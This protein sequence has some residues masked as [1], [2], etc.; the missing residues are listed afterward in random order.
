MYP[1]QCNGT[2]LVLVV[3]QLYHI[4]SG[5]G[6]NRQEREVA[7]TL[8]HG[9]EAKNYD[10]V[11]ACP[12]SLVSNTVQ[13]ETF[14]GENFH[15]FHS[16]RGTHERFPQNLGIPHPPIQ[17][18]WHSTKRFLHKCLLLLIYESFLPRIFPAIRY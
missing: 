17:L 13:R 14:E 4:I 3:L 2:F 7:L 16:L 10:D 12:C 15:D 9:V 6:V 5:G 8:K 11:S 1:V 18:S